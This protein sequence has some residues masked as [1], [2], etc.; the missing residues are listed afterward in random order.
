M[1]DLI[2]NPTTHRGIALVFRGEQGTGKTII[3]HILGR[4]I[5]N[6]YVLVDDPRYIIG[7]FNSHMASLL[8]LQA[9]EGFWAG[10]KTA[11]GRLKG[12]V[13]S[14]RQQIEFKGKDPITLANY[15]HLMVTSNSDWVVPAGHQE[16]RFAVFDVGNHCR[17]DHRY[18]G[19]M[20]AELE[21]G[22]YARLLYEL[23]TFDL[24]TVDLWEIPKTAALYEQK[25]ASLPPVDGWWYTCLRRGWIVETP[26]ETQEEEHEGPDGE[27]RELVKT[28]RV[29]RSYTAYC[30]RIG[31]RH[32]Q[33]PEHF[34]ITLGKMVPALQRRRPRV[35]KRRPHMYGFPSLES[36]RECFSDLIQMVIE[37]EKVEEA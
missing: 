28:E 18:F 30:D 13:T 27:W 11:E 20:L 7:N 16:R 15:V 34:G 25:I 14:D 37:W 24:Q 1:A 2:Q 6:H 23:M 4:L 12:L 17:Q 35:G 32:K 8:L 10:D 36:C 33:S 3:G 21:A 19:E 26:A 5:E 29:Y 31:V 22:G 9:D